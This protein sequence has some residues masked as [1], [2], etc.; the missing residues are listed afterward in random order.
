M[1]ADAAEDDDAGNR[2]P[3]A[4]FEAVAAHGQ[5]RSFAA[6]AILINEG[7]STDS[8]YVVLTGRVKAYAS[9]EDGRE[10]V[11]AE[12]GPG[13]YFGELSLDGLRRSASIQAIEPCTCRVVQ[14]AQL[15]AFLAEHPQFGA[16]LTRKLIHMVRRLTEQVR[17]LALQDVY[18]RVVNLLNE[19][20]DPAGEER[21]LRHKLTQ[22]DIA[23]RV[24]ASR[25]MVNRVMKEL[26]AGGYVTQ[27]DGRIVLLRKPPSAW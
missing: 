24:G 15:Q 27:R 19:L 5:V 22:Q 13:E 14:G 25:E 21:V 1:T 2:L 4:L 17:S 7:D 12:Y 11:L 18:G 6:N 9:S 10:V 20:S 16:H 23:D 26:A 8:L 3:R